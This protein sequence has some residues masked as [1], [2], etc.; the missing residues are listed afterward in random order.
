VIRALPLL[1]ALAPYQAPRS[2]EAPPPGLV[3]VPGGRT[4]VGLEVSELKK[5]LE[6]DPDSNNYAGVL[7]AETPQHERTLE[8]FFLML[9]EVTSEQYA[10][11][12]RATGRR[13]PYAWGRGVI[14]AGRAAWLAEQ[15]HK[16]QAAV[17]AGQPTPEPE[18]FDARAWWDEHWQGA[19]FAV[20]AGDERRPVVFVDVHD[21]RAYA[22]WAGLRLP[23]EFEYQRAVRGESTREYPWGDEWDNERFAATSLLRKKSGA[24]PVGSFPA[25]ASKQGLLDLAGN[26]WEWTSSAYVPYPGY[27]L[28]V[29][30]F[31]FGAKVR[32]VNAVA[33]WRPSQ[34]VVVGGSFQNGKLMARATTRRPTDETQTSDA[35]GFRCAA[36]LAPGFDLASAI[37]EEE[38]T[39]NARPQEEGGSIEFD[40]RA[41]VAGQHWEVAARGAG[42]LEAYAL[43]SEHRYALFTPVR[44]VECTDIVGFERLAAGA[45]AGVVLGFLS[46]N[47]HGIEPAIEPGTYFLSY[48]AHGARRAAQ[49][50]D[51]GPSLD[52]RL[53]LDASSDWLFLTRIDG[54]PV[55][56]WRTHVDWGLSHEGHAALVDAQST[57]RTDA[58]PATERTLRF[59]LFLATRTSKKGLVFPIVLRAAPGELDGSWRLTP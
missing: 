28:K 16:R 46:T 53:G 2:A 43:I 39:P 49:P 20:P 47:L 38:L 50:A 17:A 9:T 26:V 58:A 45:P 32:Q 10:A 42:T 30:E 23:T 54:T 51:K 21:A 3:L 24:F 19:A 8:S 59:D 35:L 36:S 13:P 48:R 41:T 12:L 11:Y 6:A 4:R 52:E 14:E 40:V 57:P 15:E 7:S 56:A 29:Y 33:D 37:L 55:T 44:Q 25:G 18:S 22:R 27:E 5:I 1:L 34:R 31:G